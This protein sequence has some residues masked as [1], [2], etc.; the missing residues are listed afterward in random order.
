MNRIAVATASNV[1]VNYFGEGGG[2]VI[3]GENPS[4]VS[5]LIPLAEREIGALG[6]SRSGEVF[7]LTALTTGFVFIP[8]TLIRPAATF[9]RSHGRRIM[10]LS[11]PPGEGTAIG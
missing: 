10:T 3:C 6:R 4:T 8:T 9:S 1:E 11:R 7:R 2:D 5:P